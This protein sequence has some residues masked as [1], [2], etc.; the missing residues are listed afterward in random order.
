[1]LLA[2][3]MFLPSLKVALE[4]WD[5]K[6]ALESTHTFSFRGKSSWEADTP[7]ALTV[8]LPNTAQPREHSPS[9]TCWLHQNIAAGLGDC[10]HHKPPQ[11]PSTSAP[12]QHSGWDVIALKAISVQDHHQPPRAAIPWKVTPWKWYEGEVGRKEEC[13]V[14]FLLTFHFICVQCLVRTCPDIYSPPHLLLLPILVLQFFSR[15]RK[16]SWISFSFLCTQSNKKDFAIQ[17][18]HLC[19]PVLTPLSSH[20]SL[21]NGCGFV[22]V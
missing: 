8:P 14:Y 20:Y 16:L 10:W 7:T 5:S 3:L 15:I 13:S 2:V 17:I 22:Q 4:A 21:N 6:S 12:C 1:M 19:T 9:A 11:C 18:L